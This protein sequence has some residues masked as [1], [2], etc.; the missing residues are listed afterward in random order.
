MYVSIFPYSSSLTLF[1]LCHY[2]YKTHI[3]K[4]QIF[5]SLFQ[6]YYISDLNTSKCALSIIIVTRVDPYTTKRGVSMCPHFLV[7][8]SC[9]RIPG[10][11][12]QKTAFRD[13]FLE[14]AEKLIV[15][16]NKYVKQH[17]LFRGVKSMDVIV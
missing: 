14:K 6:L 7:S 1:L 8:I 4:F 9:W 13:V 15:G 5:T 2:N 17:I 3:V 11:I 12:V 16:V 10:D